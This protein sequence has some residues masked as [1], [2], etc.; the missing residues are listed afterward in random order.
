MARLSVPHSLPVCQ[1]CLC[2][3]RSSGL[4]SL[5]TLSQPPEG[6][7]SLS[8]ALFHSAGG[9]VGQVARKLA[10]V[11]LVILILLLVIPLGIG[12][13]MGACPDCSAR[14]AP[15]MLTFCFALVLGVVLLLS[16]LTVGIDPR[17][18]A[19][20]LLLLPR[21]IERPPRSA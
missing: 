7:H 20:P 8:A 2:G 17:S 12:M 3:S 14:G 13:A 6:G 18:R 9:N 4:T 5:F 19:A 10:I 1:G 15:H 11:A 16:A 21:L